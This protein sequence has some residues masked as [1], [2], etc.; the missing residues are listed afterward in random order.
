MSEATSVLT[1]DVPVPVAVRDLP[2]EVRDERKT[3]ATI[4]REAG[5]DESAERAFMLSKAHMIRTDPT[6]RGADRKIVLAELT[7][8][9]GGASVEALEEETG[10]VPGGVGYGVMY[11]ASFKGSFAQGT[12]LFFEIICPTSPSG[13]PV[14]T[15]R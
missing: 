5:R 14:K 9:L 8:R 3:F 7:E 6:L 12:S 11:D 2:G 1:L 10:P 13:I 4:S 15:L